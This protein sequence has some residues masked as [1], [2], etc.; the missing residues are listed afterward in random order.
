MLALQLGNLSPPKQAAGAN[1]DA[2]VTVPDGACGN[3]REPNV[4]LDTSAQN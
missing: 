1:I 4:S 2:Y 3:F